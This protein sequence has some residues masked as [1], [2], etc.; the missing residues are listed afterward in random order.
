MLVGFI[1]LILMLPIVIYY[2]QSRATVGMIWPART[3]VLYEKEIGIKNSIQ[4]GHWPNKLAVAKR[5]AT[6]W[7]S[8]QV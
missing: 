8:E 3:E 7:G 2:A 4:V 5:I 6:S 1:E